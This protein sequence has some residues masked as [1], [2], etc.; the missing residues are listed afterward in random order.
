MHRDLQPELDHSLSFISPKLEGRAE[1]IKEGAGVFARAPVKTGE[2]LVVWGGYIVTEEQLTHIS[3]KDRKRTVLQVEEQ[4]YLVTFRDGPA[5]WV[6]H[7][8]NPN[9]GMSGQIALVAMYNI[10][11]GNEVCLDYA[12]ADGSPFDEFACTCGTPH[13]RQQV[14]GNDWRIP[15]LRERYAGY[16]SPYLQRRIERLN[17]KV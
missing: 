9:A 17:M 16:F 3:S 2:L 10:A 15:E 1:S 4:L 6:N 14:T 7:S 11:P 12:M 5:E 8:C 13:C